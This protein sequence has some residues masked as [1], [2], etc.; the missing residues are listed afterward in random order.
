MP[1]IELTYV[2]LI[3]SCLRGITLVPDDAVNLRAATHDKA[4]TDSREELHCVDFCL[5]PVFG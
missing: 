1:I 4:A 2:P 5:H 3:G